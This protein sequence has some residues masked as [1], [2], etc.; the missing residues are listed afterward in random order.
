MHTVEAVPS[1][2]AQHN[3]ST[4]SSSVLHHQ[5]LRTG[6]TR[7]VVPRNGHEPPSGVQPASPT[8]EA[9]AASDQERV[10]AFTIQ[11]AASLLP[12]PPGAPAA[13]LH[14]VRRSRVRVRPGAWW[15]A[16]ARC[17]QCRG[18]QHWW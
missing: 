17:G 7:V 9:A 2:S 14:A 18:R 8:D 6:F 5:R 4:S 11:R 15:W 16:R 1:S 10:Q 12:H 3:A 13:R